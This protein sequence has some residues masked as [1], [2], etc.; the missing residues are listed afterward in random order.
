MLK[1]EA[2]Y[3]LASCFLLALIAVTTSEYANEDEPDCRDDCYSNQLSMNEEQ[4]NTCLKQYMEFYSY[5]LVKSMFNFAK[6]SVYAGLWANRYESADELLFERVF[7]ETLAN[8]N[9]PEIL[10]SLSFEDL[11]QTSQYIFDQLKYLTIKRNEVIVKY[12]SYP[13]LTCPTPCSYELV[14]WQTLFYLALTIFILALITVMLYSV[15]LRKQ[16]ISLKTRA[17]NIKYAK[18]ETS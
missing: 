7:N 11:A 16:Y 15:F 12:E 14:T 6:T 10:G 13:S 1:F 4:K 18:V 5:K 3:F 8:Y 17:K 2:K 9:K